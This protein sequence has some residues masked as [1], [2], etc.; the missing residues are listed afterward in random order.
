MLRSAFP[1]KLVGAQNFKIILSSRWKAAARPNPAD[2]RRLVALNQ[3]ELITVHS[4][5]QGVCVDE[6]EWLCVKHQHR[7]PVSEAGKR[8]ELAT[9]FMHWLFDSYL[10]PLLQVSWM[11]L[12]GADEQ[13]TFYATETPTTGYRTV[14]FHHTA[15]ASASVPHLG[16]LAATVLEELAPVCLARVPN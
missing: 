2:M 1:A 11:V 9:R 16:K 12:V 15:W 7:V 5:M 10:I 3:N 8:R 13:A 14:Y 4:I 6:L